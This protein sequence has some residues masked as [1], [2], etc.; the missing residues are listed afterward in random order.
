M[1]LPGGSAVKNLFAMLEMWVWSLGRDDPLAQED[2]LEKKMAT[3]SI[4]FAWKIPWTEE[5]GTLQSTELQ[6]SRTY[7]HTHTVRHD[8]ATKQNKGKW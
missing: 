3:H 5:P 7:T 8:L 4:I 1:S 2:P 6:K